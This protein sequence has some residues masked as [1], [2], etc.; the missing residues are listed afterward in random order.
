MFREAGRAVDA[1][2]PAA[3][4][5][6]A[7]NHP[8]L[9]GLDVRLED[10][11][12]GGVMLASLPGDPVIMGYKDGGYRAS[13]LF[14]LTMRVPSTPATA[15]RLDAMRVLGD[16]AD[17]IEDES[18]WPDLPDGFDLFSLDVR[19]TPAR[20][21]VAEDGSTDYQATFELT[22]RRRAA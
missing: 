17:T 8:A 18:G 20:V 16:V 3:V 22:Y 12:D 15:V 2:I 1:T 5:T 10:I 19:M 9:A 7:E 4:L 6:W 11:I 21:A 13:Y 14:S